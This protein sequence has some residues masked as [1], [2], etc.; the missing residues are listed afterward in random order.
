MAAVQTRSVAVPPAFNI[1]RLRV[2]VLVMPILIVGL[3]FY[4][5][6]PL[7]LILVNSFNVAAISQPARYG[8]DNWVA[9]F[10]Q[11]RL[12]QSLGNTLIVYFLYETIGFPIAVIIAWALARIRM[13]FAHGLEFL[14]WV[15]F[16][17]PSL[18]TT[19]GWMMLL[20]PDL[21]LLNVGIR[22]LLPIASSG[23]FN[24]FS[25]PGIVWVHLMSTVI[26]LK[27]MLL[28]PA[29]RNM[30]ASFEEASRTFGASNL[31]T[32]F[33]ITLPLMIPPMTV[34]LMLNMVRMF[35]SFEI[36]QIIG[37][38]FKFFVYST[39][40]Y[41]LAR[42]SQPPQYGQATAL[43]SLTLLLIALLIPL[44]RWLLGRRQVTT[45]TGQIRLGLVDI[46]PWRWL[47][48]GLIVVAL[49]LL[50][51][52][53]LATVVLGSFMTRAGFFQLAQVFTLKHW[54]IVLM[55]NQFRTALF[56]T[57]VLS[58]VA[59]F[60]GP[61]LFSF[62]AYV[63]VRTRWHGRILLDSIVW[64]S[65]AIPGILAS[66]G[67]LWMFLSTPFL[68]P[69]YGTIWALVLVAIL[70]GKLTGVQLSK[71]VFLQL[72]QELEDAARACGGGWLSVYFRI[73][74]PLIM[75]TLI[76]IGMMHFVIAAQATSHVVLLATR[77]TLTLSLLALEFASGG[78]AQREEAGIIGLIIVLMTVSVALVARGLGSKLGVRQL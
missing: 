34:V 75:P 63:L 64:S 52:V 42:A 23:P 54:T 78:T 74:L 67:L 26:S 46:G 72:G 6:Y 27:V 8:L 57:L 18:F 19:I 51:V 17:L 70:Q 66:L 65:G 61:F 55:D 49:L 36:E 3:G 10:S 69:L 76:L 1:G 7:V 71:A 40:I 48:F 9:A 56:N 5:V 2:G 50:I 22:R 68:R 4:I 24:I 12:L 14:F 43:A 39:E 45:V 44:Q 21:G 13:P 73:W 11:P 16:M 38:P 77:D 53:P 58:G 31:K 37:T 32:L 59:A 20:D 60:V 28:T 41:Q 25:M 30:D 47:A 62:I 15:S 33:R 35:Q 29:F